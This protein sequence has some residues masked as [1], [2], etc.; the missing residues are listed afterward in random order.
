MISRRRPTPP[1][2]WVIPLCYAAIAVP[3][4]ALVP[5]LEHR[6]IVSVFSSTVSVAAALTILSSITSGMVALTGIVFSLDFVMVQF[7]AVAYSP[8][9]ISRLSRDPVIWHSIGVFTATFLY[10]IGDMVWIYRA[11]SGRVPFFSSLLVILLTLANVGR[12]VALIQRLALLQISSMLAFTGNLGRRVIEE[13]YPPL[14]TPACAAGPAE[15]SKCPVTQTVV[16][17]GEP[18]AL[19]FIDSPTLLALAIR[20][21]G[22]IEVMASVGDTLFTGMPLLRVSRIG[23]STAVGASTKCPY[24]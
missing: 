13:M 20:T 18:L 4:G 1:P 10:T 3:L 9:L 12:F 16:Q 7:N 8:R 5:R 14:T 22:C 21:G 23:P 2:E 19:Q 24:G 11:A 15:F 17:S 6:S